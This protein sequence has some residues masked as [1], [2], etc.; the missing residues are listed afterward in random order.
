M[1]SEKRPPGVRVSPDFSA[2]YER[3]VDYRNGRDRLDSLAR[4]YLT[5]LERVAC[6]EPGD[7]SDRQKAADTYR[8]DKS[9]L[10][11]VDRL[12]SSHLRR[13]EG[14][15]DPLQPEQQRFLEE[16]THA[17]FMRMWIT[18]RAPDEILHRIRMSDLPSL[19]KGPQ[20]IELPREEAHTLFAA[21]KQLRQTANDVYQVLDQQTPPYR[22]NRFAGQSICVPILQA[23][24]AEYLLKGLSVRENGTYPR[25]HD[26]YNLYEALNPKTKAYI[27]ALSTSRNRM[28]M[29]EFLQE[30]WNDFVNWR[31]VMEGRLVDSDPLQFDK[32]L[33]VLIAASEDDSDPLPHSDADT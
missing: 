9:V 4:F 25:T 1:R 32:A 16:A 26:L 22:F 28:D 13:A 24:A 8:I 6:H 19:R 15:D 27:A 30:H 21:G 5:E 17:M 20:Q 2:M 11:A 29:P 18:A 3:R 33:A 23:L 31:Y 7:A 12:S 14:E 10:K